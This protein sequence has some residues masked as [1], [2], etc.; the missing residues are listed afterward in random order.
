VAKEKDVKPDWTLLL[1]KPVTLPDG[2][3]LRTLGDIAKYAAALPEDVGKQSK[4]QFA[5]GL[6]K[7]AAHREEPVLHA[8]IAFCQALDLP[9]PERKKKAAKTYRIIG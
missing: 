4:W 2:R 5:A 6:I 8:L 1:D 7:R 9:E 3:V